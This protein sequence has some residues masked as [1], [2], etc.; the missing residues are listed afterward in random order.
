[1]YESQQSDLLSPEQ[2]E[3]IFQSNDCI[4]SRYEDAQGYLLKTRHTVFP[5]IT[6]LYKDFHRANS[7]IHTDSPGSNILVIEH[8]LEGR[9]EFR[10]KD[11][12]FYLTAGDVVLRRT[13]G[14]KRIIHFPAETYRGINIHIDLEK[15]PR[16]FACI[17]A[18]VDVEP[19][20]LLKKFGLDDNSFHFLRKNEHLAHIF[21]EFYSIPESVQKGYLK[22]KI[23][24]ILLF[25]TGMEL[26]EYDVPKRRLSKTQVR[27]AT[28]AH[29]YLAEH[30]HE[31][32]TIDSLA[33]HFGT[34]QTQL[35]TSFR[36]VYG[37]S[38]QGFI[39]EQKMRAAA[40]MLQESDRK[41]TEIAS[42]FGYANASKFSTAFRRIMGYTP[43]Q[44]R[45]NM[46]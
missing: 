13:D 31:H 43:A 1:M 37:T 9:V 6:L 15:T 30:M 39:C 5:G 27:I 11:D 26:P 4:S 34:S 42:E 36:L 2:M 20:T 46:E 45:I 40:R 38:V 8:C 29:A 22:V 16:C 44:Y 12:S 18:D 10:M 17:L 25:L 35:K 14:S 32:I 24:E 3:I 7:T 21:K 19:A 41:I 33:K 28:D 23:L